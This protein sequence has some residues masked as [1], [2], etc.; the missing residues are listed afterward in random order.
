MQTIRKRKT[1]QLRTT[2]YTITITVHWLHLLHGI[3]VAS[4]HLSVPTYYVAVLAVANVPRE[5][6]AARL[7]EVRVIHALRILMAVII[8][9]P[10]VAYRR[11]KC[12][13][14]AKQTNH[15]ETDM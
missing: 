8:A 14:K 1:K 5:T 15:A 9:T 11:R 4:F 10:P 2:H 3:F 12:V 13:H 7:T 6:F